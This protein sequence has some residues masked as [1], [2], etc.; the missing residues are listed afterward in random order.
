LVLFGGQFLTG[1]AGLTIIF[2]VSICVMVL[3]S[4]AS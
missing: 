4:F 1:N 3:S 2:A